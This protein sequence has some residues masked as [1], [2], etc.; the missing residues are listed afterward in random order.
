M[1]FN[2]GSVRTVQGFRKLSVEDELRVCLSKTQP[3]LKEL[4]KKH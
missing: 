4:C 1:V 3:N 2:R